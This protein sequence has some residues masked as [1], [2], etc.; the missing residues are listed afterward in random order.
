MKEMTGTPFDSHPWTSLREYRKTP[1]R[2]QEW[3]ATAAGFEA[4]GL[5]DSPAGRR[6]FLERL[7]TLIDW[8]CPDRAG[9]VLWEGQGLQ[10]T[11]RR[12]WY[13]G[14]QEFREKLLGM[15]GRRD[16][17]RPGLERADRRDHG[18]ADAEAILEAG[19]GHFGLARDD[20]PGLR[21]NDPR[22]ALLAFM[23]KDRT[24]V[25]QSWIVEQLSMGTKPY[26][27]RLAGEVRK[28]IEAGDRRLR[29]QIDAIARI[30]T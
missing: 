4:T 2:R 13:F 3:M 21:K 18:I 5:K 17:G 7:E 12:G 28:Q 11:M 16:G 23:I 24:S 14:S 27:S 6:R 19:L 15:T 25:P 26:V 20:L 22:K 30:I 1:S 9:R 29:S 8:S 10:S